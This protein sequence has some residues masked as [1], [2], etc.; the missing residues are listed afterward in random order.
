[1]RS[2]GGWRVSRGMTMI[3]TVVATLSCGGGGTA[4]DGSGGGLPPPPN[5]Q[6]SG[7][8][9]WKGNTTGNGVYS[10]ETTLTPAN[11]NVNQFG[12]LGSF[13]ADGLA[14]AQ[15][16][17]VS[18]VDMGSGGTHNIIIVTTEHD[19]IYALDADNLGAGPLWHRNYLDPANG[20]TTLPDNFGGRTT[21]GG[22]V[23]ITGA[24]VIDAASGAVYF[25]TT[26]ARNGVAEQWL[27]AVDIRT[28]KDFGPGSLKI[29]ASVPGDGVASANGQ[30]AFDPSI[31]NQRAGLRE[32]NGSILVPWGS[33][34]DWGKYHGW[35]M[36]FDAATLQRKAVFNPSPQYQANDPVSG[37]ADHGGGGSFWQGAAAPA[38]D[39]SGNI[40]LN[41]ADGSLMPIKAETT[42][43][44]PC[45]S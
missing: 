23:G 30:I 34:S 6:F 21:L 14:E 41:A 37:P 12:K 10:S 32:L 28:G 1:M 33:F 7:V 31:Q 15:P 29:E 26:L 11:V 24:P 17:Y 35:L 19:S 43:A 40:Y 3:A 44:T 36:A 45:L 22:E 39:A 9:T 20:V 4:G 8:L 25:V 18:N 13:Q 16:L 2:K 5:S 42:T 38:I 27:R